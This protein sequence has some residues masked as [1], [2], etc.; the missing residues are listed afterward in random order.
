MSRKERRTGEANL[1]NKTKRPGKRGGRH[2]DAEALAKAA[3]YSS[4][5]RARS[6]SAM[7]SS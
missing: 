1:K 6:L 3:F 4:G 7:M 2:G 5:R